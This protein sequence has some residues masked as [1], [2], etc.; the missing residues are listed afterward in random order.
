MDNT[1]AEVGTKVVLVRHVTKPR[2]SAGTS[3]FSDNWN[4]GMDRFIGTTATI[5][6]AFGKDSCGCLLCNV[7]ENGWYWRVESMILASDVPL[8]TPEQRARLGI[9]DG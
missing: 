5:V 8:L 7:K 4:S 1:Y 6:R 9:Q 2:L 3:G